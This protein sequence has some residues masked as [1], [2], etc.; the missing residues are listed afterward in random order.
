MI[1]KC[2][3]T[4]IHHWDS[5]TIQE[6]VQW[7]H[8]GSPPPKKFR[9]QP[10]AGKIMAKIFRDMEGVLLIDYLPQGDNHREILRWGFKKFEDSNTGGATREVQSRGPA[11]A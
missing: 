7:K 2:D 8:K 6:S 9:T 4:W 3:E 1:V 5:E 10:S 11:S